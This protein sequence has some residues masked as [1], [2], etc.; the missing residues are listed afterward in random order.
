MASRTRAKF[1]PMCGGRS[2]RP[3]EKNR[4]GRKTPS[5]GDGSGHEALALGSERVCGHAIHKTLACEDTWLK[6]SYRASPGR[7]H[8]SEESSSLYR[9]SILRTPPDF[10]GRR[11][12][13]GVQSDRTD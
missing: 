2:G 8:S 12:V 9:G 6:S 7:S 3:K 10:G 4:P 1:L 5:E 11:R 13:P